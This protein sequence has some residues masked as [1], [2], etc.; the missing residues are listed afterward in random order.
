MRRDS[1][2]AAGST[3]P[4]VS[5]IDAVT[6][7]QHFA[8]VTYAVDPA[9]L[10]PLVHERFELDCVHLGGEE[11]ALV[12]VVPFEDVDFRAA[13]FPTPRFRFA[14]TNYRVYVRDRD[15]GER[16]AWFLGTTLHSLTVYVPRYLWRLPWH[17]GRIEF[18]C[19]LDT[20]D[21]YAQ[22]RMT[23]VGGWAPAELELDHHGAVA[24]DFPGFADRDTALTVLTHPLRGYYYRRDGHLGA[25]SVWHE[26]MQ[27]T[28]ATCRSAHFDLLDRLGVV[29][30][31]EQGDPYN[32]LIQPRIEFIIHLPPRLA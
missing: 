31:A 6:T 26:R 12:S 25:Y 5:G 29:P 22:Y 16:S 11:R 1:E 23:T 10:R 13:A 17:W 7:L 21:T 24:S 27:V 3:R 14:Q 18:D 32:V 9:R 30:L 15:T 4:A 20:D 28:T 2:P 19:Q 8:V